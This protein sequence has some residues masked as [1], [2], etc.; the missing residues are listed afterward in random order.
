MLILRR[1]IYL[2]IGG[3]TEECGAVHALE[4]SGKVNS[5]KLCAVFKSIVTDADKIAVRRDGKS[6]KTS[7]IQKSRSTYF[8]HRRGDIY[9]IEIRAPRKGAGSYSAQAG[10]QS[11]LA[12]PRFSFESKLAYARNCF[13]LYF[14]GH[15]D[16][17]ALAR[18]ASYLDSAVVKRN[19]CERN[20]VIFIY[21]VCIERYIRIKLI[22]IPVVFLCAVDIIVPAVENSI[23]SLGLRH[24]LERM[25]T[26][27]YLCC[28]FQFIRKHIKGYR[29][30]FFEQQCGY[31]ERTVTIVEIGTEIA[32]VIAGSIEYLFQYLV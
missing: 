11:H 15:G 7:R 13:S 19:I 29:A 14:L 26:D 1:Y 9:F 27:K 3:G 18:I 22:L 32:E 2:H 21:P 4:R 25:R 5:A 17:S 16:I 10:G 12:K 31:I 28:I 6:A 24:I 8:R 23:K 20:A 30:F